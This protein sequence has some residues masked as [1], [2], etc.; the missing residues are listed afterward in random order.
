MSESPYLVYRTNS[1]PSLSGR[2]DDE[3]WQRAPKS[4]RFGDM[5]TGKPGWFDTR[6]AVL[7]DDEAL[8]IG[9]WIE[10]PYPTAH[11]TERDSIIFT[12]NDIEIFIDG[13]D[14]YYEFELNARN[15][16]YEVFFIWRDAMTKGSRFDIPE[17]DLMTKKVYS[18]GG[19]FDRDPATFWWGTHPRGPRWA[20][21]DWDF[22]GIETA[23][24]V[25]GVLNDTTQVSRGWTAEI[26]L[27]WAGMKHLADGRPLPPEEGDEW[28]LFLGRFQQV[29]FGD[30]AETAA[31]CMT[32]HGVLDTHM[33]HNFTPVR[34]TRN[35]LP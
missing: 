20:Y 18:F 4:P 30:K 22:P 34:F 19:N 17:F 29:P 33:P 10:D 12:E 5:A 3:C 13:G 31:W 9:F 7:W 35:A 16:I 32:P 14:C 23:V 25:D 21:L 24:H 26:K 27:P 2:L 11:L 6:S 8:Y 15:T 1:K 28:R